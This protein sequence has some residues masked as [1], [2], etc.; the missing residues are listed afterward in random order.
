MFL[1]FL[2]T[3]KFF[4]TDVNTCTTEKNIKINKFEKVP[5][6]L[7]KTPVTEKTLVNNQSE[8][9]LLCLTPKF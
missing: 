6:D 4:T 5:K 2:N 3:V 7:N 8:S 1:I 9:K